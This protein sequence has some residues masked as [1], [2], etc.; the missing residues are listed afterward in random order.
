MCPITELAQVQDAFQRAKQ[1]GSQ[2]T[3]NFF[4]PPWQVRDWIARQS[5]FYR[6]VDGALLL[7]RRDRDF[8]HLY[9]VA[10]SREALAHALETFAQAPLSTD[11][12]AD[13]VGSEADVTAIAD[14]Y[15]RCGFREYSSLFRMTC[16]GSTRFASDESPQV[17]YATHDDAPM[18]L[19]FLEGLLD[20]FAE[21]IPE[22]DQLE[23][24]ATRDSILLARTEK[25]LAGMLLFEKSGHSAVL[26]YWV[27]DDRYRNQGIGALL[28]KKFF[29]L[30]NDSKRITLWVV[31]DNHDAIEKYR[32]YGFQ[33]DRL[34]DQIM[35]MTKAA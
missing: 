21:Q 2:L 7:F 3:T 1:P 12:T 35:I 15:A 26:R 8:H 19:A 4:A 14:T 29:R 18:I 20:R 16:P 31:S 27:V 30:C 10:C 17:V 5:L 23:A 24:A 13:L 34:V 22:L 9:H 6:T 11:V 32:H 25:E 28:I 33:R